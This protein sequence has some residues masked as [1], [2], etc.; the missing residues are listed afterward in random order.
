MKFCLTF[1]QTKFRDGKLSF[2][3]LFVCHTLIH[4]TANNT[5]QITDEVNKD[6]RLILKW[7][8]EVLYAVL[9]YKQHTLQT[10]KIADILQL[11][12]AV[13]PGLQAFSLLFH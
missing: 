5:V 6:K 7:F 12:A 8:Q 2:V 10:F 1:L 11:I 9:K 13:Q 3:W 4:T